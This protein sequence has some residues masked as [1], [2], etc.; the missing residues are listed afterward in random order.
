MIADYLLGRPTGEPGADPPGEETE[1]RGDRV[2][3]GSAFSLH[4]LQKDT[5]CTVPKVID[6]P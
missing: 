4:R 6:F 2:P 5:Q 3:V 1:E